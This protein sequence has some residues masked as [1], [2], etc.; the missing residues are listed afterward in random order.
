M[1]LLLYQLHLLG[2]KGRNEMPYEVQEISRCDKVELFRRFHQLLV[3]VPHLTVHADNTLTEKLI[4]RVNNFECLVC[5]R[6][7]F[8]PCANTLGETICLDINGFSEAFCH[9]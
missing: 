8:L 7:L 5:F 4:F 3:H 1:T 9:L 6:V 2:V